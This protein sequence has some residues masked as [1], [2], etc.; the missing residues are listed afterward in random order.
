MTV[1][2]KELA[3]DEWAAERE[4]QLF[5]TGRIS[6]DIYP[7]MW[8]A[9]FEDALRPVIE[10]SKYGDG[11]KKFFFTFIAL[12]NTVLKFAGAYYNRKKRHVEI[13]IR[14]P[15]EELLGIGQAATIRRMEQTYLEAIDKIGELNLAGPFD[16][17]AFRADV[18]AVFDQE[19]WYVEH[20]PKNL[21]QRPSTEE[22]M[23][24]AGISTSPPT[25][26]K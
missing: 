15:L 26:Q 25:D 13:A 3:Q 6:Q 21:P 22:L 11:V 9:A 7:E 20:L 8:P 18:E 5:V 12:K 17:T 23:A 14:I 10:L 2:T 19:D 24:K 1:S 4:E 16:H